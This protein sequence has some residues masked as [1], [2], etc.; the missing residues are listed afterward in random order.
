MN[1]IKKQLTMYL[2]IGQHSNC[3]KSKGTRYQYETSFKE[4]K[5]NRYACPSNNVF[6]IL[7]Y[8]LR[9]KNYNETINWLI[10]DIQLP[11]ANKHIIII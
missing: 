7:V 11:I 9:S 2:I 5:N 1:I 3:K 4:N 10:I 8:K 6:V